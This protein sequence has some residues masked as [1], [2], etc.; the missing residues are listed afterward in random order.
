MRLNWWSG[1]V[2]SL[3]LFYF[4]C[5][6]FGANLFFEVNKI[7][8]TNDPIWPVFGIVVINIAVISVSRYV[9]KNLRDKELDD[10]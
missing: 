10:S 3:L 8:L 5:A 2:T 7:K 6:I 4:L 9:Y 1:F